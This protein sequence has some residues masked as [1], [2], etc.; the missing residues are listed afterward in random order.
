[1]FEIKLII[2]SIISVVCSNGKL[3]ATEGNNKLYLNDFQ[4]FVQ[5][6]VHRVGPILKLMGKINVFSISRRYQLIEQRR[7]V[8]T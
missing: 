8:G 5:T 3:F 6:D 1:M 7:F 4:I 2:F